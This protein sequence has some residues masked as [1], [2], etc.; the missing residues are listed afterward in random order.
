VSRAEAV[1]DLGAIAHNIAVL[2]AAAGSRRLMAVVKADAYG[3]GVAQVAPLARAA[4]ADWLGVALPSE[5]VALRRAGDTGRLMAWLYTP[6]DDLSEA[7]AGDVDLSASAPWGVAAVA[8][9]ARRA[10]RTARL[11]LKIDTG[12][13]RGGA[14]LAAWDDLLRSA[15]AE[16]ADGAV[17][18]VGIWSHLACADEPD[19]VVTRQ[20]CAVFEQALAAAA[21]LGVSPQV[22]HIASSGA[23]LLAPDSHYD[24]VRCGIACYG[25]SPGTP[26]GT[27]ADLGLRPA[28]T[29]TAEVA[30]VK[31]VP[32]GQG[33]SYGLRYRT[34]GEATLALIP[35]GY[36]D[37]VPR[38]GSGTLPVGLHGRRYSAAGTIAMDQFVLDVG[39]ADVAPGDRVSLFGTGADGGP[40]ADEWAA[41][42]GTINY[43]IVTR[44]G[45]RIPRSY[46]GGTDATA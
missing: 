14:P 10:G 18:I 13:G 6:G 4:G 15:V 20:Q 28:M 16:Q 26:M 24:M 11:H 25:L 33:V 40:T 37:G 44:L 1:I 7:V 41:A 45:G 3:H 36:A 23:T 27:S 32:A 5:A 9:A 19:L 12:L 29:V 22:R 42:C 8:A 43:E 21:A 30:N 38:A 34:T 35:V 31:R 17:A 2:R 39:D 46:L